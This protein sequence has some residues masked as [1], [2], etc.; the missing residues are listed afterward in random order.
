M[1]RS[2]PDRPTSSLSILPL[3]RIALAPTLPA[4]ASTAGAVLVAAGADVAL[5]DVADEEHGPWR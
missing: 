2:S 4:W 1:V 5:A 3:M